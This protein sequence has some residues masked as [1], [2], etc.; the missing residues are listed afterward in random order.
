MAFDFSFHGRSVNESSALPKQF[1]TD[2]KIYDLEKDK[3]FRND[4]VSVA[5]VDQLSNPGDYLTYDFFVIPLY[6]HA[7]SRDRSMLSRMYVCIA[8]VL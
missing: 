1:F 7:T 4:W 8:P 3:I 2:P 5:R 6:W